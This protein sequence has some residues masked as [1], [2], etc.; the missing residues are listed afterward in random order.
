MKILHNE[1][2]S[3]YTKLSGL[4]ELPKICIFLKLPKSLLRLLSNLVWNIL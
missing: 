3:K 2:L 4:E 1:P